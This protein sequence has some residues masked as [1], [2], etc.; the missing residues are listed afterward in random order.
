MPRGAKTSPDLQRNIWKLLPE[1]SAVWGEFWARAQCKKLNPERFNL[2]R[3]SRQAAPREKMGRPAP[4]PCSIS[5]QSCPHP[6]QAMSRSPSVTGTLRK[7][8][9]TG[10]KGRE[11]DFV[12]SHLQGVVKKVPGRLQ[13]GVLADKQFRMRRVIARLA[14]SVTAP[15]LEAS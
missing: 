15:R 6:I 4:S 12:P 9:G 2:P 5:L 14:E 10:S 8:P 7:R 13:Q 1:V 3:E 11:S